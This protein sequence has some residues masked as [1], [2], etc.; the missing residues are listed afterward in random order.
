[1]RRGNTYITKEDFFPAFRDAFTQAL[2]V[3]NIYGGFRGAGLV[4]LRSL[5]TTPPA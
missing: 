5:P 2:T 3:K 4:P 1:M